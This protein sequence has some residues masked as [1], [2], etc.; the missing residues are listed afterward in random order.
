MKINL[1]TGRKTIDFAIAPEKVLDVIMGKN[2]PPLPHDKICDMIDQGIRA[3]AP[4]DI[5]AR[6]IAVIIP[7]DTRLWARGDLF[8]PRIIRTLSELGVGFDQIRIIIALG[9][10]EALPTERFA[11]LAGAWTADRVKILNSA[12]LD[13]DRLVN[14]GTTHKGTPLFVT[15]EAWEADHIIIFGGILHHM[16]AGFGG[17]RKYILPGIAGEASI[18]HNHS[19]AIYKNGSPHPLVRQ[20]KLWGNPVNE[21]L[22]DGAAIFLKDKTSCYVAVAANG[23]GEL[24][25]AGV[26]NVHDTFMEGCRRLNHACCVQVPEKGDFALVSAGGHRADGQLYQAT[27]ALFNAVNVVKKGGQIL[28]VAACAQGEGNPTFARVL[29]AFRNKPEQLGQRLVSDFDMPSYV[30]LRVIDIL[31]RFQVTLASNFDE[32]Q[33]SALGFDHTDNMDLYVENLIGKGY[34]IPFGENILPQV[35]P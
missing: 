29:K 25:Y 16:L 5:H 35:T 21:D 34:V 11:D 10:H 27:K 1:K 8:V 6:T 28:F 20:A 18:R 23:I 24:F 4:K 30:A 15:K 33:T 2:I 19:L 17:G 7:D 13:K 12:G 31:N 9:T 32:E 3:A 26:G 22:M 14:I